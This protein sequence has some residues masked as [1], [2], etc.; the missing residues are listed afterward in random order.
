MGTPGRRRDHWEG[1]GGA[2]RSPC[3]L[4]PSRTGRL[5]PRIPA[6]EPRLRAPTQTFSGRGGRVRRARAGGAAVAL[7]R[8]EPRE[9]PDPARV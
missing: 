4:K 1:P 5:H 9:L 3:V 7:A 2:G 8:P 6:A